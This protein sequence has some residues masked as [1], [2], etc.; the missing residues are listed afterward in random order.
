MCRYLHET[1]GTFEPTLQSVCIRSRP[2]HTTSGGNLTQGQMD[3]WPSPDFCIACMRPAEHPGASPGSARLPERT[4]EPGSYHAMPGCVA[5]GMGAA[6]G[7]PGRLI[8]AYGA[9][10][11]KYFA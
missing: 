10:V 9:D 2:L 11:Y 8:C 7:A 3:A 4:A 5:A 1:G 6:A